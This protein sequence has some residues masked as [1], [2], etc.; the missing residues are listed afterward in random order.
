MTSCNF[1]HMYQSIK[2]NAIIFHKMI[3]TINPKI[4]DCISKLISY[5]K[6]VQLYN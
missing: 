4:D 5:L 2:Y 6:K 3:E 1:L